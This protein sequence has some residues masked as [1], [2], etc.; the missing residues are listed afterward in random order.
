MT[1]V[2][3]NSEHATMWLDYV[4]RSPLMI[5]EV[6][7][8]ADGDHA[9]TRDLVTFAEHT[10]VTIGGA[11]Q[12]NLA[13]YALRRFC[14]SGC[15]AHVKKFV[16]DR[17]NFSLTDQCSVGYLHEACFAGHLDV[18]EYLVSEAGFN[19]DCSDYLGRVP[20]SI[21]LEEGHPAVAEFLVTNS[22]IGLY[23]LYLSER[24]SAKEL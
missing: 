19:S 9:L 23:L 20:L 24:G 18:V 2:E 6:V 5:C 7:V 4:R 17:P 13:S 15:L 12:I 10:E 3:P 22:L 1:A 14:R 11:K 8:Q 16:S 21:A